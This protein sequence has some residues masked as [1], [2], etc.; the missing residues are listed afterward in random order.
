MTVVV[1]GNNLL[2]IPT[3]SFHLFEV[4]FVWHFRLAVQPCRKRASG[5]DLQRE[6]KQMMP[7]LLKSLLTNSYRLSAKPAITGFYKTIAHLPASI[8]DA[9]RYAACVS[10]GLASRRGLRSSANVSRARPRRRKDA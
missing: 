6:K 2:H 1:T 10:P 4:A 5:E 3:K 9:H 7:S 8:K